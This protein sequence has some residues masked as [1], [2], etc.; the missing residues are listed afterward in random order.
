MDATPPAESLLRANQYS[1]P[2]SLRQ[3]VERRCSGAYPPASSLS[4]RSNPLV[5][6]ALFLFC[7]VHLGWSVHD[8][9]LWR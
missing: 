1:V 4:P 9:G 7:V 5:D 6:A 3:D 8:M 2:Q